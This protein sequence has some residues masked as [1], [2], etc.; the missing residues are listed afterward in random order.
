MRARVHPHT[1]TPYSAPAFAP[2]I[3][4]ARLRHE[5]HLV[6][7][8]VIPDQ[9]VRGSAGRLAPKLLDSFSSRW[10]PKPRRLRQNIPEHRN[11]IRR[12]TATS[13]NAKNLSGAD[14]NVGIHPRYRA[15]VPPRRNA[16]QRLNHHL[17]RSPVGVSPQA[18]IACARPTNGRHG[19]LLPANSTRI[20]LRIFR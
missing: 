14:T 1:R 5:T 11:V 15:Q 16:H 19:E 4:E 9:C 18:A 20:F 17:R 3:A 7:G 6:C 10:R 2:H 13:T 12:R 8:K